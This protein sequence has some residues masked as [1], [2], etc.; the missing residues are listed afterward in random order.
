MSQ[1]RRLRDCVMLHPSECHQ[2]VMVAVLLQE[3]QAEYDTT[4]YPKLLCQCV[5]LHTLNPTPQVQQIMGPPPPAKTRVAGLP[6]NTYMG[7]YGRARVL[8]F[9]QRPSLHSCASA[10]MTCFHPANSGK[11]GGRGRPNSCGSAGSLG[12]L[13][14]GR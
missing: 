9:Q 7:G 10:D 12:V 1:G 11:P 14:V 5:L 3:R 2:D 8:T 13:Q 6:C 4:D